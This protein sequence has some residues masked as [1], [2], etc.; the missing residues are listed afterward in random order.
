M[1]MHNKALLAIAC[2]AAL[3]ACDSEKLP[4]VSPSGCR[5]LCRRRV[6]T[7]RIC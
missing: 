7:M 1:K 6:F 5:W 2:A 4:T 3:S